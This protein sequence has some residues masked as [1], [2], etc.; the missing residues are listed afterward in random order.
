MYPEEIYLSDHAHCDGRD[1]VNVAAIYRL[2]Y[3]YCECSI[4]GP[5]TCLSLLVLL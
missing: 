2:Q 1:C 5:E 3:P 4:Y